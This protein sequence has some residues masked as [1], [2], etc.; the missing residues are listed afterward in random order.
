MNRF[1]TFLI[2][3]TF[4]GLSLCAK[5]QIQYIDANGIIQTANGVTTY[6][7][8]GSRTLTTGW[9]MLSGSPAA[10][11]GTL[12]IN[13]TVHLILA[14]GC[15]WT[16]NGGGVRV[17]SG[18]SLTIY[19]Q[20]AGTGKLTATG[21]S[22]SAGIGGAADYYSNGTIIINGGN[23]TATGSNGSGIN[24]AGAGIGGGGSSGGGGTIIINGGTITAK[25]GNATRRRFKQQWRQFARDTP[26]QQKSP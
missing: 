26:G 24:G 13:G 10:F 5:A 20:S 22:R 19:A 16:I 17:N 6:T 21:S 14:D 25:G 2:L 8:G 1:K 9:Y 15:N 23:L 3:L 18:N 4:I 7:T 12:T 11:D